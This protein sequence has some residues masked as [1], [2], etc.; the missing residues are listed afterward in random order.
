MLA[1][2]YLVPLPLP[3]SFVPLLSLG[4]LR[5]RDLLRPRLPLLPIL[6]PLP[7]GWSPPC[8]TPCGC[9][10]PFCPLHWWAVCPLAAGTW[11]VLASGFAQRLRGLP[12]HS[13]L[14]FVLVSRFCAAVVDL[15]LV[16]VRVAFGGLLF[17][18]CAV[19]GCSFSSFR[20][21]C[22]PV[23]LLLPPLCF[24]SSCVAGSALFP[25]SAS[26]SATSFRPL[27]FVPPS[28][29]FVTHAC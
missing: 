24:T 6:P 20:L 15:R 13:A 22:A 27:S 11:R 4:F 9:L 26:R 14:S 28:R 29:L 19:C 5:V 25:A 2:F 10:L 8:I 21:V 3:R 17:L 18:A 12:G 16:S 1:S 7:V 23:W